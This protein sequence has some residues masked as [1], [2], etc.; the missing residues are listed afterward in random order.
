MIKLE[1]SPSVFFPVK[2]STLNLSRPFWWIRSSIIVQWLCGEVTGHMTLI[3]EKRDEKGAV[4]QY[5][6]LCGKFGSKTKG[7]ML[8]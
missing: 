7:E 4:S 5:G 3:Y 2:R 8:G 6:C 1:E